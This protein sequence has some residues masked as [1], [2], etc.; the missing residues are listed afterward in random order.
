MR[1]CGDGGGGG[2]CVCVCVRARAR[3]GRGG[4]R[5]GLAVCSSRL[6]TTKSPP[7]TLSHS[8]AR[9]DPSLPALVTRSDGVADGGDAV[10]VGGGAP[11]WVAEA[12]LSA[13]VCVIIDVCVFVCV[14]VCVFV[15]MCVCVCV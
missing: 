11:G 7:C 5:L 6:M 13:C 4:V 8:H 2:V 3:E 14:R 1:I 9:L 12:D 15:C 10:V